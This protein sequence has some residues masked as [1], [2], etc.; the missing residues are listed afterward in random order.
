MPS[1]TVKTPL[2]HTFVAS[3]L[4]L[5]LRQKEGVV[6]RRSRY[7]Q[8]YWAFLAIRCIL[9]ANAHDAPA[10]GTVCPSVLDYLVTGIS[11][12]VHPHGVYIRT[13]DGKHEMIAV[14]ASPAPSTGPLRTVKG[15]WKD[16]EIAELPPNNSSTPFRVRTNPDT[17]INHYLQT[18][19]ANGPCHHTVQN[20]RGDDGGYPGVD[21]HTNHND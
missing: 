9:A 14:Q 16:P 4:Y 3:V 1:P 17:S 21:D 20:A 15:E 5:I 7:L 13:Y 19:K 12:L 10:P 8:L 11:S 6:A 2:R 18:A